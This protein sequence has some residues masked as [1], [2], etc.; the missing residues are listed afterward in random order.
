[1]NKAIF[2]GGSPGSGK[3]YFINKNIKGSEK[4]KRFDLD[5][6]RK[7][8]SLDDKVTE[9]AGLLMN[10]DIKKAISNKENIILEC[11]MSK[12]SNTFY[13]ILKNDNYTVEVILVIAPLDECILSVY[14]RFFKTGRLTK[15]DN[16]IK[17]YNL[18]IENIYDLQKLK[19]SIKLFSKLKNQYIYNS[20]SNLLDIKNIV[21]EELKTEIPDKFKRFERL[22]SQFKYVKSQNFVIEFKKLIFYF[23]EL[24]NL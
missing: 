10:C 19:I 8:L 15:F 23:E 7:N 21:E 3:T 18:F 14:E 2:V 4:Y 24:K 17:K 9:E 1:M 6:Y 16:I 5:N 22:C 20:K 11:T 12:N 13:E